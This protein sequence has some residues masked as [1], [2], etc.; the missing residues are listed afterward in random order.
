MVGVPVLVQ[1]PVVEESVEHLEVVGSQ[2]VLEVLGNSLPEEAKG[3][4]S[5]D[6]HC[7][8]KGISVVVKLFYN[9]YFKFVKKFFQKK[10]LSN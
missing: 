2:M 10:T 1:G 9:F 5:V 3:R 7:G 8:Q 6:I 4:A